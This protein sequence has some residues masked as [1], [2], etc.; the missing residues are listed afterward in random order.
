MDLARVSTDQD[1]AIS[2]RKAAP[3]SEFFFKILSRWHLTFRNAAA[4]FRFDYPSGHAGL[5]I[6][7]KQHGWPDLRLYIG[8]RHHCGDLS[9]LFLTRPSLQH[10]RF[11]ERK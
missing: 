6:D 1:S 4:G 8:R 9:F 3:R 7:G 10:Q 2:G 11:A 5:S